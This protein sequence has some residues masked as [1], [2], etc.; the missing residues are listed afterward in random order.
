MPEYTVVAGP[1]GVGKSTF[2]KIFS[3]DDAIIF[4][5]DKV[6]AI[7]ERQ[8]PDIPLESIET[9]ITT[10]YWNAEDASSE[11]NQD[12]TVE[13]NLRNNFLIDRLPFFKRRGYTTNL[14]YMIL[15]NVKLSID[16]V[17]LRAAQKGHYID[18][19]SIEYNFNQGIGM[20]KQHFQKFD[21]FLLVDGSVD[22]QLALP[23]RLLQIN[24]QQISYVNADTPSWATPLIDE[25]IL[26]LNSN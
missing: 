4:D 10:E 24:N 20:L 11:K 17:G 8:Y 12:L 14:I 22:K 16:R 2:S 6:K 26:K 18:P 3:A 15:P 1:N 13:T 23:K 25:I 19:E 21:N 5:P 7:K 9:M